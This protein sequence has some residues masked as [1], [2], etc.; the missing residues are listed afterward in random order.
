MTVKFRPI[1]IFPIVLAFWG[2][3]GVMAWCHSPP[4]E[5]RSPDSLATSWPLPTENEH[6]KAKV[7]AAAALGVYAR[8]EIGG[9]GE[10]Q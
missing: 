7:H 6:F 10:H 3:V 5:D 9:C 4:Y 2:G 1:Y 8:P